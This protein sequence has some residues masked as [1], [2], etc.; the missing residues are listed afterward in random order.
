M[1]RENTTPLTGSF[2]ISRHPAP[3]DE[4]DHFECTGLGWVFCMGERASR[5][6][7]GAFYERGCQEKTLLHLL[8][9]FLFLGIQPPSMN[10][11]ILN[12][13]V[14]AGFFA[15]ASARVESGSEREQALGVG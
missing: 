15:W 2:F 11:T 9:V 7:F 12:A 10:S 3:F 8:E 1:S 14:L 5:K 13:R 4:L 6:R